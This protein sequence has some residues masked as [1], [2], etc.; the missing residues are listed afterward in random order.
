MKQTSIGARQLL[1]IIMAA[2]GGWGIYATIGVYRR[3]HNLWSIP[4]ILGTVGLFLGVWYLALRQT[5]DRMV[6]DESPENP[7]EP[8][9]P[10]NH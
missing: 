1:L 4:L 8:P 2:I 7:D 9:E 5:E 10:P 3:S 6:D